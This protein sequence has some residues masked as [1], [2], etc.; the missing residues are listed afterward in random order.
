MVKLGYMGKL[1][2]K[3]KSEI[4]FVAKPKLG[5]AVSTTKTYWNVII[6]VKHPSVQGKENYVKETLVNPDEIRVSKKTMMYIYF[7]K[8]AGIN[9]YV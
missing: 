6:Y 5:L 4:A 9:F 7:I 2:N 3:S 1:Q 8:N